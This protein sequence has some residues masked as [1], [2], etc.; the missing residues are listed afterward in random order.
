MQRIKKENRV[1]ITRKAIIL[2]DSVT[3]QVFDSSESTWYETP[4]QERKETT[5]CLYLQID[6]S[7]ESEA[8]S[9][10]GNRGTRIDDDVAL[11]MFLNIA[12]AIVMNL[13]NDDKEIWR[14]K[15]KTYRRP[16][17]TISSRKLE[18]HWHCNCKS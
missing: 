6:G 10:M 11:K 4:F 13:L 2:H 7:I 1:T 14:L 5:R 3:Q 15:E 12:R 16:V 9:S 17:D 8:N 18:L